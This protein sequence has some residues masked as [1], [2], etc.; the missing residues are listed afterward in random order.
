MIVG[1]GFLLFSFFEK[2][3]K[4]FVIRELKSKP[5]IHKRAGMLSFP[6]ETFKKQDGNFKQTII[7]LVREEI[8][9]PLHQ[10]KNIVMISKNFHL[11]PGRKDIMTV[12]GY[13]VFTGEKNACFTPTDND[14]EFVGWLTCEELLVCPSIR[15]ETAPILQD[16]LTNHA[17]KL[18]G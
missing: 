1:V 2:I 15:V 14:I 8:G 9:I 6:L 13:G 17:E 16:F 18:F 4:L 11:I 7:R 12:Y 10:V 3:P 5:E